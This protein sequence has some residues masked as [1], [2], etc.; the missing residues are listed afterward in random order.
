MQL[1]RPGLGGEVPARAAFHSPHLSLLPIPLARPLPD[2]FQRFLLPGEASTPHPVSPVRI[3]L[4]QSIPSLPEHAALSTRLEKPL[5][6]GMGA[7]RVLTQRVLLLGAQDDGL[8][9]R[10]PVQAELV[11]VVAAV[12]RGPGPA[13]TWDAEEKG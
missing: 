9:R 8:V 1:P 3:P 13:V 6:A 2:L 11:A 5:G 12:A 4:H 7:Q 10:L